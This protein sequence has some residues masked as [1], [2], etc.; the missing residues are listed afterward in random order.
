M[1]SGNPYEPERQGLFGSDDDIFAIREPEVPVE[2]PVPTMAFSRRL[3]VEEE[4][5]PETPPPP[6]LPMITGVFSFPFYWQSLVAWALLALGWTACTLGFLGAYVIAMAMLQAGI[7]FGFAVF[8]IFMLVASFT[9][10]SFMLV[11]EQTAQ[12]TDVV[13]EWPTGLWRD[14]FWTLPITVG[15]LVPPAVVIDLLRRGLGAQSWLP[16]LPLVFFLY[17]FLLASALDNGSP[18]TPFSKNV[19][20]SLKSVWWAW[21]TVFAVSI[22]MTVAWAALFVSSFPYQPWGT[23]AAMVPLL[24]GMM[25]LY[26]RMIGRLLL[27]ARMHDDWEEE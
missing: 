4:E 10:A 27:C 8:L 6:S 25:L 20:R 5:L 3:I 12:G 1:P 22:A 11:I 16:F 26:A 9:S 19:L 15:L 23:V 18:L 21:A 24:P 17:P 14:W 2:R 7:S 13:E